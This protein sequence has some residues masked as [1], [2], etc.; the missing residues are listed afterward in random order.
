MTDTQIEEQ[1]LYEDFNPAKVDS[2]NLAA[3]IEETGSDR[4]WECESLD[5]E[6]LQEQL[7]DAIL[8]NMNLEIFD[9][10]EAREI[11]EIEE[12]QKTRAEIARG[13]IG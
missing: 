4:T 11:E 9:A 1:G 13:F 5:P 12:V 8:A 6:Y 7:R 3:F 10:A 2:N